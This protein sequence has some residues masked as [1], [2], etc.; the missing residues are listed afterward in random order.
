MLNYLAQTLTIPN[1]LNS[2]LIKE[3]LNEIYI[4]VSKRLYNKTKFT[5]YILHEVIQLPLFCCE[6]YMMLLI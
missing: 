3:F 4:S 1:D 6:K 5:F 2:N